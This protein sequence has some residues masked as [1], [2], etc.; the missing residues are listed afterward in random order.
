MLTEGTLKWLADSHVSKTNKSQLIFLALWTCAHCTIAVFLC[1]CE[2]VIVPHIKTTGLL[3]RGPSDNWVTH[4]S[5]TYHCSWRA[6]ISQKVTTKPP[7][8]FLLLSSCKYCLC[9][10]VCGCVEIFC[11]CVC[12]TCVSGREKLISTQAAS[13]WVR[14]AER[15]CEMHACVRSVKCLS[16]SRYHAVSD[17]IVSVGGCD[18]SDKESDFPAVPSSSSLCL[19][20][21][22]TLT[23]LSWVGDPFW[24]WFF[25]S[26]QLGAVNE[27][28]ILNSAHI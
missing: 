2:C 19:G 27:K 10:N 28:E 18:W 12:M 1:E 20:V 25:S 8:Q 13:K 9:E 6:L 21:S 14:K 23:P 16:N 11:V 3:D 15:E 7:L 5:R 17:T 22:T 4:K 26:V 24:F